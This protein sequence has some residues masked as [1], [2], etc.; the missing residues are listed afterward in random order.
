MQIT[1]YK[2]NPQFLSRRLAEL[3]KQVGQDKPLLPIFAAQTAK[4]LL[5]EDKAYLRFGPYWW[6]VKR[7]LRAADFDAGTHMEPAWDK[8]YS[9][10]SDER[11]LLAAWEFADDAIGRFGVQTRE[12]DLD[13]MPFLLFDPDQEEPRPR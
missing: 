3:Q 12:Y 2:I 7:I 9:C 1:A 11:T 10:E 8:E 6:A 4:V 5:N 13:G